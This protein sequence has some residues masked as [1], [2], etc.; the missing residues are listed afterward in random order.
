MSILKDLRY[1]IIRAGLEGINLLMPGALRS[2]ARGRGLIFTLHH[3]RPQE[4]KDFD[5]NAI[6]T[7]TPEFLEE[8]IQVSLECGLTPVA[9]EDLP[10][11]LANP[12]DKR[13]FVSFTLDDGY[14]NNAEFAAP[15]F[16][17]YGV[18]YTIFITKGF[19]ERTRSLWWE[20]AEALLRK[21]ERIRFNFGKGLETIDLETAGQKQAAF[22][23]FVAYVATQDEDE[24]VAELDVLAMEHGIDPLGITA[25]LTMDASELANLDKDPLA[26]FGGHTVTHPNL[27]RVS[28][29]R[30]REEI[31]LSMQAVE[32]YVG[33][34]PRVFAYPYGFPAAAGER[35]FRVA[36]ELG[37]PMAV[38]TQ[39][40][41][42]R[43]ENLQT[44]TAFNR[45]SLNGLYQKRR[46]VR[47]LISGLPF[48]FA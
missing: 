27:R 42:L 44:P 30:L 12:A 14:R 48:R 21:A 19:V 45:V 46:Y 11:L 29:E 15:V 7:V 10:T 37:V 13:H 24:A 31:L 28:E 41:M 47:A 2:K 16:R 35:E 9:A 25:D 23:R 40:G 34:Y 3:V 26:R 5:P 32:R 8:A 36:A 6:L 18:P 38:T 20:T 22:E 33:R 4:K 17:K 43:P 39:P 1:T